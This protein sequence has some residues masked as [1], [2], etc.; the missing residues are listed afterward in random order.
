MAR[1]AAKR[2]V[3]DKTCIWLADW[4]FIIVADCGRNTLAR[5]QTTVHNSGSFEWLKIGWLSCHMRNASRSRASSRSPLRPPARRNRRLN[6]L[7]RSRAG[8][9]PWGSAPR[10]SRLSRERAASRFY[11][12]WAGGERGQPDRRHVPFSRTQRAGFFSICGGVAGDGERQTRFGWALRTA[13]SGS[14]A[15]A[16]HAGPGS[17]SAV[18][19]LIRATAALDAHPRRAALLPP[20][21]YPWSRRGPACLTC[22]AA[23][24]G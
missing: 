19:Q 3:S 24:T 5:R 2:P 18:L 8:R 17:A 7:P 9:S 21:R 15:R 20:A 10:F 22:A 11:C 14:R 16:V 4:R 1:C 12:C 13:G 6:L 23:L